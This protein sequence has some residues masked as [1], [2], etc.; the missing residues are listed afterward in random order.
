[1]MNSQAGTSTRHIPYRGAAPALQDLL[2]GQIDFLMGPGIAL[3]QAGLNL[4]LC[5]TLKPKKFRLDEY[6]V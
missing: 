5:R 1:M 4:E 3:P 2:G 6:G